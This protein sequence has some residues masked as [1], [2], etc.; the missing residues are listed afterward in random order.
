GKK[1]RLFQFLFEMLEDPGMAHCISWVQPSCGIFQFSSQNKDKLAEMW[2]MRKGNKNTMT[3]QK[4]SRALRNYA[5]TGEITK[6][7][8]KLT[9]QFSL[10]ILKSLQRIS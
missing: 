5:R 4:M 9:Y 8:R 2:G 1:I 3:Y 6:V 10:I 7:K